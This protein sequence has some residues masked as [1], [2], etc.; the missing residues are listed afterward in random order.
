LGL[1]QLFIAQIMGPG[2]SDEL[3]SDGPVL[4][5]WFGLPLAAIACAG[6]AAAYRSRPWWAYRAL[7]SAA[8]CLIAWFVLAAVV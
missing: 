8:G 6:V 2:N 1:F 7:G 3:V 4:I 5:P